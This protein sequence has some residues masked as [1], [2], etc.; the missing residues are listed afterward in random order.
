[1]IREA[2]ILHRLALAV[3][4]ALLILALLA[5]ARR[6]PRRRTRPPPRRPR[7]PPPSPSRARAT[8]SGS[9]SSSPAASSPSLQ[10]GYVLV[11]FDVPGRHDRGAREVLLRPARGADAR[12]VRHTLDLGLYEPR[13][14]DAAGRREFRG[15][16]GSSHPDV[17]LSPE[18]FST[19]A[20]VPRRARR[21][22]CPAGPRAASGPGPIR[23]GR[24]AA[25]LGARRDR[26]PR[27][28]ATPT[29]ASPGA[30]RSSTAQRPG[31]RRPSPTARRR[32]RRKPGASRPG[33]YTGDLHVHAEHS[34]LG[35]AT[36]SETFDYA[37]GAGEAR[38]HHAHR[39][40]RRTRALGRDRPLP[41]RLRRASSSPARR[42]SSPTAG[43]RTT[44]SRGRYVDY[45]TG[46]VYDLRADGGVTL[47][48]AGAA[49]EPDPARRPPRRRLHADQPPDDLPVL[50]PA[51]RAALPRL[52]VGLLRRRRRLP[53]ASTRS[54]STRARRGSARRPTRSRRTAIDFYEQ[55]L[56]ARRARR[57]ARGQRLAPRRPHA[58]ARRQ[59]PVGVGAT[60]VYAKR[61][62]RARA[63]LRGQGR[64]HLR[65]DRRRRPARTCASPAACPARASGRS[66]ATRARGRSLK[67]AARATG[68]G[69]LQLLR[70]GTVIAT[71]SRLDRAHGHRSPAAT[72]CGVQRRPGHR[73]RRHADLVPRGQARPG[74]ASA[75]ARRRLR[76]IPNTPRITSRWIA[77]PWRELRKS[78]IPPGSGA[79]RAALLRRASAPG[80]ARAACR[81]SGSGAG[82]LAA[83]SRAASSSRALCASDPRAVLREQRR[84][85]RRAVDVGGRRHLRGGRE[86]P[87]VHDRRRHALLARAA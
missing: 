48:R 51:V 20:A 12:S 39:L 69:V 76:S 54:R 35:D 56:A 84:R 24:W 44:R 67:L 71:G 26:R 49:R 2:A 38:L 7:S 43:T 37:F 41:G 6:R 68:G 22:T 5:R 86:H 11:P 8:R 19:E 13:G 64:P 70:D 46:P 4:R 21:A 17:T 80:C 28:S 79:G 57:R 34:A 42:R 18:G 9:T 45:R 16:G 1:M 23:P 29:A 74:H 73:G 61:A 47:R 65:E 83:S 3:R 55:A 77:L 36:M 58:T 59:S 60:A 75:A 63:P 15:W 27:R 30:S 40:R 82:A 87:R 50:Q 14:G 32:Y 31:V 10:G 52:P 33:W 66:S 81:R 78:P 53:A 25:E 85:L 62:L 72:A